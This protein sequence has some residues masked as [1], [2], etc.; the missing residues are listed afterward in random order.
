MPLKQALGACA[1]SRAAVLRVGRLNETESQIFMI[2]VCPLFPK[3]IVFD[4]Y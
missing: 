1:A 4:F 3:A 2:F